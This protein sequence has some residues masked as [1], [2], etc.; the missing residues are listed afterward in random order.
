MISSN[1]VPILMQVSDI[2]KK[3]NDCACV[4][5]TKTC[6]LQLSISQISSF[7][8]NLV[9]LFSS[10]GMKNKCSSWTKWRKVIVEINKVNDMWTVDFKESR[11]FFKCKSSSNLQ[12]DEGSSYC[13]SQLDDKEMFFK[14]RVN[15]TWYYF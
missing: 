5:F 6:H 12:S 15:H 11:N 14:K 10:K 8:I 9:N 4:I 7:S 2:K 13:S 3:F 1:H